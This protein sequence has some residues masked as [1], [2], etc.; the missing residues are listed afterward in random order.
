MGIDSN[1]YF[2]TNGHDIEMR[3]PVYHYCHVKLA[4]SEQ[5]YDFIYENME[6][7][8]GDRVIVPCGRDNIEAEAIVIGCGDFSPSCAPCPVHKTKAVIRKLDP[9]ETAPVQKEHPQVIMEPVKMADVKAE[10]KPELKSAKEKKHI[11]GWAFA[12]V[13]AVLVVVS[14]FIL[15]NQRKAHYNSCKALVRHGAY[16][17]AM[18]ELDSVPDNYK[19]VDELRALGTIAQA[20][21][22]ATEDQYNELL[23][24]LRALSASDDSDVA[25]AAK[26]LYEKQQSDLRELQYDN[27]IGFLEKAKYTEAEAVLNRL[28]AV[29]GGELKDIA[30]VLRIYA[31]AARDNKAS[32]SSQLKKAQM[33]LNSIPE[34]YSG[35]FASEIA[36]MRDGLPTKIAEAEEKERIVA[37]EAAAR[38][39]QLRK[40]LEEQLRREETTKVDPPK[41][42]PQTF[43]YGSSKPSNNS[44]Y[45]GFY[46]SWEDFYED[47][48]DDFPGGPDDAEMYWEEHYG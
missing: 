12:A 21:A 15:V 39:E 2:N 34:D 14:L 4:S 29:S 44:E 31:I 10:E 22:P 35:P 20:Q 27:A 45:G 33:S 11:P 24:Q 26:Q 46:Y 47:H 28:I 18:A 16:A 43:N 32:Q 42:P 8:E 23:Q 9:P 36:E 38:A 5:R 37:E 3:E 40:E 25:H 1:E 6:L 48:Y 30:S 19:N 13:A 17:E 41:K 7:S